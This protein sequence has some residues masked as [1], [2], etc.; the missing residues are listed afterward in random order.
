MSLPSLSYMDKVMKNVIAIP[1]FQDNYIWAISNSDNSSVLVVD[2]GDPLPVLNFLKANKLSLAGIL[3]THHHADHSAGILPLCTHFKSIP[4]YGPAQEKKP[5]A[6]VTH[7]V[8]EKEVISLPSFMSFQVFDIPGHTQGHIAY[9]GSNSLFCGDTLFACGCGR[10][11]EGTPT[12]M[13]HS[14]DKIK[15]LS[16]NTLIYCG[17]EYTLSN[18]AFAKTVDPDNEMIRKR[19]AYVKQQRA[20]GL[21]S[22]PVLLA[23]ELETNPFLRCD[24]Q[25]I[26]DSV[27]KHSHSPWPHPDPILIFAYLRQWKDNFTL[28]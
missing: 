4:V 7:F 1:A 13:Y 26:I 8:H 23:E 28:S 27:R 18:I 19:E 12:Q 3:L 24:N 11:F 25:A 5:V 14:L 16:K 20:Q 22:L 17:H 21:P 2:P 10:L 15:K 6:G 9:G